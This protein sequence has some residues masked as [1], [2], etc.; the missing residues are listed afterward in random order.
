M[1]RVS[2]AVLALLAATPMARAQDH[3]AEAVASA[4]LHGFLQ[5]DVGLIAPH[6]NAQNAD[7][8]AEVVAGTEDRA[9]VFGGAHGIAAA[10]WD[11]MILPARFED[12]RAFVP[13]AIE[14]QSGAAALGS[15]VAGRYMVITLELDGPQDTTW[16]VEDLNYMTRSDFSALAQA[17]P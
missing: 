1:N 6:S 2:L 9:E 14:G 4:I 12:A 17:R 8:F 11:G 7:F 5:Q 15:G 3:S 10:G 13:Y 16:G